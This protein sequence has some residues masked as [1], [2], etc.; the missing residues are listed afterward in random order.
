MRCVQE[1]RSARSRC[2]DSL[3]ERRM[4][5][6]NGSFARFSPFRRPFCVTLARRRSHSHSALVELGLGGW[7]LLEG[8]TAV[9]T[10]P[11]VSTDTVVPEKIAVVCCITHGECV[12]DFEL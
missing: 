12:N 5:R 8:L 1:E 10:V 4:L 6:V 7:A 9:S 3:K 2:K 11:V